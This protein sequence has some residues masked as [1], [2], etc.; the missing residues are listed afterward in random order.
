MAAMAILQIIFFNLSNILNQYTGVDIGFS[1]EG[2]NPS[3]VSLKQGVW[4][5]SP[6]EAVAVSFWTA[7]T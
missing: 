3:S 4:G 1:E 2:T 5:Y 7:K 6:P